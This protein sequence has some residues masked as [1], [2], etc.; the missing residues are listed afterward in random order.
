MYAYKTTSR[1]VIDESNIY[2]W[3]VN[4][5]RFR[6]TTLFINKTNKLYPN[7]WYIRHY[8]HCCHLSVISPFQG[9]EIYYL[10]QYY[11]RLRDTYLLLTDTELTCRIWRVIKITNATLQFVPNWLDLTYKYF[12]IKYYNTIVLNID[13]ISIARYFMLFFVQVLL[14]RQNFA[15]R[16]TIL[17]RIL[18]SL[19]SLTIKSNQIRGREL[20]CKRTRQSYKSTAKNWMMISKRVNLDCKTCN[21]PNI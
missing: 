10:I 11:L 5:F 3:V 15:F 13:F 18:F 4:N 9:W 14:V 19:Q 8:L 7:L 21:S 6:K 1:I 17:H 2:N 12:S 20:A 16:T